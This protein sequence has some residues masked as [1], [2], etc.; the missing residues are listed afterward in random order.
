MRTRRRSPAEGQR[1][2]DED[3]ALDD[4]HPLA[5]LGEIAL[6]RETIAG[7]M[8][9]G[10]SWR[11]ATVHG[12]TLKVRKGEIRHLLAARISAPSARFDL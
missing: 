7:G 9:N 3:D 5:E 1:A 6:H 4:G 2:G 11:N 12:I 10:G 8:T